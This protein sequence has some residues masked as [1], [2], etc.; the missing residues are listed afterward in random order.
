MD[1]LVGETIVVEIDL[2]DTLVPSSHYGVKCAQC[3]SVSFI[4]FVRVVGRVDRIVGDEANL[5]RVHARR[6][7]EDLDT[8][9][10]TE[11][12]IP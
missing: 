11:R 12:N 9:M 7:F 2:L 6:A 4:I 8:K 10:S 3:V 5:L 1:S